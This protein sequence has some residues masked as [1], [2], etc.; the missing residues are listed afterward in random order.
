[1]ALAPDVVG[2]QQARLGVSTSLAPPPE[3]SITLNFFP[4]FW[5]AGENGCLIFPVYNGTTLVLLTRWDPV[6][7]MAA[8]QYYKVTGTGM[9]VD[10]A[11][12]PL[13]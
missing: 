12:P 13:R 10:G 4:E 2:P 6:T 7:V 11:K 8:I 9:P 5:I 1:M 3:N